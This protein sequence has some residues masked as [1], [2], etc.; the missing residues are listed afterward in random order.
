MNEPIDRSLF[1]KVYKLDKGSLS[2]DELSQLAALTDSTITETVARLQAL[3]AV[4]LDRTERQAYALGS[5][6][7]IEAFIKV[8]QSRLALLHR[9][10]VRTTDLDAQA[11]LHKKIVQV[12][13]RLHWRRT[14]LA[15]TVEAATN[16]K[17]T[18]EYKRLAELFGTTKNNI[19]SWL[20]RIR[21]RE[22]QNAG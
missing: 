17:T 20:F 15:R 1:L 22:N 4:I 2:A 3:R 21:K 13:N 16:R 12:G 6:A 19:A 9:Q 11:L 7:T 5:A 18:A 10:L 8:E 14:Q